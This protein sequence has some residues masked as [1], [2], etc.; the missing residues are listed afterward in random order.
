[1]TYVMMYII[2]NNNNTGVLQFIVA[3]TIHYET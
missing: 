1:M 2:Y 3:K